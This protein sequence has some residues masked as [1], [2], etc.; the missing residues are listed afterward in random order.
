MGRAGMQRQQSPLPTTENA[1]INQIDQL[2]SVP[3]SDIA[4][5][6]QKATTS[7]PN[8]DSEQSTITDEDVRYRAYELYL[9]RG[10]VPGYEVEDWLQAQR[11]LLGN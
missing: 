3:Q 11:E 7:L 10:S 1:E 6:N 5:A 9:Q 4:S 2:S 8:R